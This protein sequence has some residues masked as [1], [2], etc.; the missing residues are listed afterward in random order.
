LER[1]IDPLGSIGKQNP[2]GGKTMQH[3]TFYL[4]ILIC[5]LIIT[6]AFSPGLKARA[7]QTP[8]VKAE[9]PESSFQK[10]DEFFL[11]KDL[12]A[13]ATEIRKGAGF[14]KEKVKEASKVGKEDLKDSIQDL[15]KLAKDVEK[16]TVISEQKLK[17]TFARSYQALANHHYLKASESWSKKKTKETGQALTASAKYLEQTARWSGRKLET[18]TTEVVNYVSMVGGKLIKGTGYG[19]EE[20]DKGLKEMGR[21]LSRLG[22]KTE[23]QK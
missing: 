12:K 13:A 5:F 20:V 8:A 19:A 14:L 18:G 1:P 6:W 10:A 9:E 4:I 11:K 3:K 23:P 17:E 21:E 2:K 15:E 16:G 7:S 22:K